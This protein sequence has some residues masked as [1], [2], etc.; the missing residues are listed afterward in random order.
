MD[1]HETKFQQE[2]RSGTRGFNDVKSRHLAGGGFPP[3]IG[4]VAS[5]A[6]RRQNSGF[7]ETAAALRWQFDFGDGGATEGAAEGYQAIS[8]TTRYK[9]ERG[10]GWLPGHNIQ[11]GETEAP[12]L[13]R[14]SYL[15]SREEAV[16]RVNLAPGLYRFSVLVG[17]GQVGRHGLSLFIQNRRSYSFP[18]VRPKLPNRQMTRTVDVKIEDE[19]TDLTFVPAVGRWVVN[20][21][22]IEAI[23]Q[24]EA[25]RL[26]EEQVWLPYW[27]DFTTWPNPVAEHRRRFETNRPNAVS[28]PPATSPERDYLTTISRTAEY[29]LRFQNSDGAIIDPFEKEELQYST[30]AFALAAA[31]AAVHGNHRQLL[32]P[33]A[34]A[35]DHATRGLGSAASHDC[36]EDFYPPLVARAFRLLS[37]R[38]SIEREQEWRRR[39]RAYDPHRTYRFGQGGGNWNVVALSGEALY[40]IFGIK[41]GIDYAEEALERH[42]YRF[43]H[44]GMYLDIHSEALA[45][46]HFPRM[47]LAD[48]LGSGYDGRLAAGL[49][50]F[51]ERGAWTSLFLQS[52]TG[53]LPAGGRSS[54]H[55]WN[56]AAQCVTF[57]V[58]AKLANTEGDPVT[59]GVF[60]RAAR[61]SLKSLR[62]WIRPDGDLWIVKNRADPEKRH[63]Y[64]PYSFHSQYNLLPM[65][66]LAIAHEY[67]IS[68]TGIP[69][70][71]TPAEAG[72]FVLDIR[73]DFHKV[74]ANAAGT[75]VEI[76]TGA[77]PAFDPTGLIRI[78]FLDGCAQIGPSGG[79]ASAAG[80]TAAVGVAWQDAQGNWRRLA[81]FQKGNLASPSLEVSS[82]TP[83]EVS[84]RIIYR[85]DM[86]GADTV[87]E[88]YRI[89]AGEVQVSW[90]VLGNNGPLRLGWPVLI[91]DGERATK[92]A[93]RGTT[94]E[95]GLGEDAQLFSVP[96]AHSLSLEEPLLECRNGWTKLAVAEYVPKSTPLLR[97]ELLKEHLNGKNKR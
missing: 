65:A 87:T 2:Q 92:V 30:P 82:E 49:R 85:G 73:R 63:G 57:E 8:P 17:D 60:K 46:D 75:Y 66:M 29:F 33:A 13:L 55:Q 54:H 90:E 41:T 59:A 26:L 51:L 34:L 77:L 52:P 16:F 94:M 70:Q 95:V 22:K 36:H 37:G 31:T 48:M 43:T 71:A 67:A 7:S 11:A 64:E 86:K 97:V 93:I 96:G 76:D 25:P 4:G 32:E 91:N 58:F 27:P 18:P 23:E 88:S 84:F 79:L 15:W 1:C 74:F 72:G 45:Y 83:E 20:A 3:G 24:L 39:I 14:R 89:V 53:E 80:A 19:A 6:G 42:A 28:L 56:E 68:T 47:W 61:M 9:P 10:Y 44:W 50:E 40:K 38:V 69:E 62:K 5:L 12:D 78:H 35:L 81:E 21:F